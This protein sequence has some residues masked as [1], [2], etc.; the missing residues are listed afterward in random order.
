MKSFCLSYKVLLL[1][2]V[3]SFCITAQEKVTSVEFDQEIVAIKLASKPQRAL[4]ESRE[5]GDLVKDGF[6]T[7]RWKKQ[8]WLFQHEGNQFY[9]IKNVVS[10]R[11]ISASR[12]SFNELIMVSEKSV[13]NESLLWQIVVTEE[14]QFKLK[15]LKEDKYLTFGEFNHTETMLVDYKDDLK[16]LLVFEKI[17][18][19]KANKENTLLSKPSLVSTAK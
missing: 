8:F 19:A 15:S 7:T 12:N 3:G 9:K 2:I 18:G 6:F 10:N 13:S 17:E 11:F 5:N 14:N 1:V 4:F 16:Q